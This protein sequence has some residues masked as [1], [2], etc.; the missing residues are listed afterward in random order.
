MSKLL[1]LDDPKYVRRLSREIRKAC[2][3]GGQGAYM[4]GYKIFDAQVRATTP[5]TPTTAAR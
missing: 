3:P 1:E 5:M 2:G 4:G